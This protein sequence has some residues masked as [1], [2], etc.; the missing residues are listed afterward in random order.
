MAR[1]RQEKKV[2]PPEITSSRRGLAMAVVDD[3]GDIAADIVAGR[4]Y[5]SRV[6]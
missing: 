6:M 4:V 5:A 1:S 2:P 3:A